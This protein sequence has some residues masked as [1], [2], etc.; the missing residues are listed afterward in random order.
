MTVLDCTVAAIPQ[1]DPF[2]SDQCSQ[3]AGNNLLSAASLG[4][5]FSLF[6]FVFGVVLVFARQ[7]V[8]GDL[9]RLRAAGS[10]H[11][12]DLPGQHAVQLRRSARDIPPAQNAQ[13]GELE[14][15]ETR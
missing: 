6:R 11:D 8:D 10:R 4:F 14:S 13:L 12:G 15:L 3:R 9:R 5:V 1:F 7:Y 2:S